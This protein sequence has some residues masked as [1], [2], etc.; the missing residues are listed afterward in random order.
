MTDLSVIKYFPA[1]IMFRMVCGCSSQRGFCV[2]GREKE[3]GSLK[4]EGA[5]KRLHQLMT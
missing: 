5:V 1:C 4:T 2:T 3:S